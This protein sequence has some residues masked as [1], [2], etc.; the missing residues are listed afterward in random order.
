MSSRE[1]V[2]RGSSALNDSTRCPRRTR[3][4]VRYV[5]EVLKGMVEGKVERKEGRRE[6]VRRV[7]TKG[8]LHY[9]RVYNNPQRSLVENDILY[10]SMVMVQFEASNEPRL[11]R[12]KL[13]A[14]SQT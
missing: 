3:E 11:I 2:A 10:Y 1:I 4:W 7:S 8:N 12:A 6:G 5:G 9:I 13:R 14:D